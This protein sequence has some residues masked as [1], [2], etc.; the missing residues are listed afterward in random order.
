MRPRY[1]FPRKRYGWGWGWPTTWEGHIVMISYFVLLFAGIKMFNPST[2]LLSYL[3]Y[4]TAITAA[5]VVV[6][7]IKGEPPGWSW[8]GKD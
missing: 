7:Y 5:L 4:V 2:F 1:W 8:G 3:T 6:C